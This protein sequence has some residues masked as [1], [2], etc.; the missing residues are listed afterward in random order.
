MKIIFFG[1]ANISKI[2]LEALHN[3]GY[4]I[5]CAVTK[6]DTPQGRSQKITFPQVKQFCLDN[7]INFIQP[8]KFDE[9]SAAYLKN[10]KAA[11][12]IAVS[13]GKLIPE[14]VI[15]APEHKCFNIH[16]S[17]LPLYRGAAPVQYALLDGQTKTGVSSF[18]LEKT[19]DSGAVIVQKET[20]I[21]PKDNAQTLFDKL[22][23]SGIE[24][25]FETLEKIK[26][27]TAQGTPQTAAPTFAPSF[28]KEDGKLNWATSASR[29][30][31][32]IRALN[33]WPGT[34]TVFESGKLQGKR[35]KIVEAEIVSETQNA[36]FGVISKIEKNKGFEVLCETGSVLVAKVQPENK[37]VMS[38]WSFL[39]GAKLSVGDK[40][41]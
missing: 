21:L 29:V 30:N 20:E 31:N 24:V 23:P 35:L 17:L 39:Q 15:N 13:Y 1:T 26:Q 3:K 16:F 6:P 11:V 38:A 14:T 32:V 7:N 8:E 2:Y 27:G 37:P 40:F 10:L 34:F 4:E 18:W 28:K 41:I 36:Q 9:G 5:V 12:G 22:I 19:L 25:M 33:P